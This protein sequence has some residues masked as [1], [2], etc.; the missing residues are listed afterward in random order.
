MIADGIDF[1]RAARR[2]RATLGQRKR[3]AHTLGVT[4]AA[5][6]LARE[7]GEDVARARLAGLV[8]DIAR[9]WSGERLLAECERRGLGVD[10]FE[11][12]HPVVLH[13]RI[14]AELARDEFGIDDPTVLSAIRRHTL[15]AGDMSR[16]DAILFLAD[17]LEPGRA[18]AGRADL[19]ARAQADLGDGM[20]GVLQSTLACL[21]DR[22][23]DPAP[24]TLAA[25]RQFALPAVREKRPA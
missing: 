11:R 23:L 2:V 9:L 1:V 15:G 18:F 6:G 19:L 12:A 16:L 14:G 10:A 13:A 7:H 17:A 8:H 25:V 5:E 20:R 4:R 22:G 21:R 3:W 24:Q